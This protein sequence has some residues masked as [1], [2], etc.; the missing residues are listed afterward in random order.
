MSA[1]TQTTF[2]RICEALCGLE[3][4]VEDGRITDVRPDADHVSTRGFGCIKGLQQHRMYTSPD[5]IERPIRRTAAGFEECGWDEAL[6]DIGQTVARLRRDHGPDSIAMYVGTAAGFG[7]LHPMFAQGFMQGVGSSSFYSSATQ[8]CANKFAV[9]HHMYGFPFTQ[10]FPDVEQ[11][12]CLVIVGAN[13]VVSKWSFLQVSN[14]VGRL[15]GMGRRGAKVWVIDPRR[16]ETA[17]VAG[18]HV[19]IRPGT[20][21]FFYLAF[22]REVLERGA[23][24][25]ARVD[26]HTRN[27][28]RLEALVAPWTPE[29]AE[30]V[31][32]IPADTLR[33]IVSDYLEADGA[34]LYSSTGVNMGGHGAIGFWIQEVINCVTGNLDRRGGTLVGRGVIDFPKFGKK[35]GLLVGGGRSRV[36]DFP[37]VNDA[38][39]GGVLA[40]E[41]L[42]PGDRQV[43]ALFV[44]GGNPLITMPNSERLREA[45]E[46]LE[47]LVVI[48]I[49]QNETAS[50]AHYTLPA[51]AP[52][53]RPDLPFVFPLMLGLQSKPYLQATE[54]I[55]PPRGE[56]R[57]EASIY[58]DICKHAGVNLF[59][60]AI[61]Q[62]LLQWSMRPDERGIPTVPQKAILSLLLRATG[63]GGFGRLLR[64]EHGR[65]R[66]DHEEGT[67]LGER[68]VTDDGRVD[69]APDPLVAECDALEATFSREKAE[70]GRLKLITKRHVTT[71]NSWTHNH[72]KFVGPR[73]RTNHLWMHPEDAENVGVEEGGLVDVATPTN[74]VR[75]PVKLTDDLM[76]GVVALPHGW[77]PPA[78]ARSEHGQQDRG[79]EREPARRRRPGVARARLRN[80]APDRVRGR[81]H[82]RR[83]PPQHRELVRHLTSNAL[84]MLQLGSEPCHCQEP[85]HPTR[86]IAVTGGPGAG[87]TAVLQMARRS[88]CQHL[89]IL[90]E[91]ASLIFGGGFPRH[92]TT[93]GRQAAQRAIFYVQREA[94]RLVIG[95]GQVA[96]GLCDRGTLDGAAYWPGSPGELFDEVETTAEEQMSRY[97]L[98]IHLETPTEENGYNHVNPLRVE[99]V[100][101]AREIDARIRA[102]WDGHPRRH[103]VASTVDFMEKAQLALDLIRAE[104]PACCAAEG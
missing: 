74:T 97:S 51:T 62:K 12:E 39:P 71:H 88:F 99:T 40:D 48:D 77:G 29:R 45:F 80:G 22:L 41:I 21:A 42:T 70:A 100:D 79:R 50:L 31:T 64:E 91:A 44:T 36:G 46:N 33:R 11:T 83:R 94:E 73:N 35:N 47:L 5:R 23:V 76:P 89:A 92:A 38:F 59:D 15:K 14:P 69:L 3:V 72:P 87:K 84:V 78:G 2:C 6:G 25:R 75:L 90:P 58:T 1:T 27:F 56:Q 95:E 32:R 17:Q 86:L 98:V 85:E 61:A 28:D 96:V 49:F 57:D 81:S 8:D 82:S 104:I 68:V 101:Q 53:Q 20:D 102:V 67:F 37:R 16:T 24:D 13:P 55:V 93:A 7:V 63:Q 4:T 18:E 52:F 34:A 19:F 26:A 9:S 54:A 103:F 65:A 30:E 60:S 10:P 66:P 43:K